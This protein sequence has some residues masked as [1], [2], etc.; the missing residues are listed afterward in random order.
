MTRTRFE[1]VPSLRIA[2]ILLSSLI[3]VF[4]PTI[5]LAAPSGTIVGTVVDSSGA[6]VA[7]VSITLTQESTQAVRKATTDQSGTFQFPPLPIGPYTLRAEKPGLETFVQKGII[8]QVDQ[9]ITIPV[10][11]TVGA[12]NQEVTVIGNPTGVDLVKATISE[13]VDSRRIVELP[14]NGRDPLQLQNLMPGAGPDVNNVSHGQGQ[15]GGIVVNGNRPASNYYLIDGV[16]SVDSYLAVAPAF[17]APDAL[18]EF[19]MNTSSFSAEYGRNSGALVNAVTKSGTNEWHGDAFEFFRNDRLNANNFFANRAGVKRPPYKLNQFG[20]TLGGP[21]RKDKTFIFGYFQQT[22]RRQSETVTV[23]E[24]LSAQERPDLNPLGA[25]FGDICPGS[26]CPRDPRTGLPFPNNTIPASRIDPVALNL[27]KKLMPLPNNGLSY[28]W[29]GFRIG[30]N[31]SLS[32]PQYVLRLDHSFSESDKVFVRYFYNYDSIHGSG[33][34]LPTLPHEKIFRNNNAGVNWTHDFSPALLNQA[35][36]GFNR[37]YHF[38]APTRKYR[39]ERLRRSAQR[40][41][42]QSTGRSFCKCQRIHQR[43]GR[44]GI[45]ATPHGC[46]NTRTR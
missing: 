22:E 1:A 17:P 18:E 28:T 43:L 39:V 33:G 37:M 19:S 44:W 38:R 26:S 35:L 23:N 32:E 21:I 4:L 14:L 3:V 16:D 29:S 15:H 10:T 34:N 13:V 12:V 31:D 30:N 2:T 27:I 46:S 24:V 7:D 9:N 8:L 41:P 11:L 20:G 5:M 25:N 36:L 45:S 40:R 6:P 42:D